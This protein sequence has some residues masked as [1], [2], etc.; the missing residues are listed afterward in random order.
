M[1]VE[2]V[3]D[4][5]IIGIWPERRSDPADDDRVRP[6][7]PPSR[8]EEAPL[9]TSNLRGRMRYALGRRL[10]WL[11][12]RCARYGPR[13]F[14][15]RLPV[16]MPGPAGPSLWPGAIRADVAGGCAAEGCA[17]CCAEFWGCRPGRSR[18]AGWARAGSP[19]PP[20]PFLWRRGD[21]RPFLRP[22]SCRAPVVRRRPV[23]ARRKDARVAVARRAV[24]VAPP[25]ARR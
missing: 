1:G 25:A 23:R 9:E 20:Y 14:G 19:R 16:A 18:D 7:P 8:I 17:G 3:I 2:G 24:L 4:E 21:D 13:R 10:D 11:K 22:M 12:P 15:W 6:M 5:V